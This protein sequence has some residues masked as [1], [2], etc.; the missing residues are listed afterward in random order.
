METE[1]ESELVRTGYYSVASR[2][3]DNKRFMLNELAQIE[4]KLHLMKR[5]LENDKDIEELLHMEAAG[6]SKRAVNFLALAWE[7]RGLLIGGREN[8]NAYLA[9]QEIKKVAYESP[10]SS[11]AMDEVDEILQ[12][13]G[14][15]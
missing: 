15:G 9:I 11:D 8:E 5:L 3:E 10:D 6:L 7:T 14:R 12:A 1:K 2:T 13:Y 4:G